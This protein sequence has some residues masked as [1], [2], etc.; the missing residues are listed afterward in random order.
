MKNAEHLLKNLQRIR[1]SESERAKMRSVIDAQIRSNPLPT[2]NPLPFFHF[3]F[4]FQR[5]LIAMSFVALFFVSSGSAF[6][7]EQSLP[8]DVLYGLKR[9]VNEEVRGWFADSPEDRALWQ[10]S[11]AERRLSEIESLSEQNKLSD[12]V[13]MEL[14]AEVDAY[15]QSALQEDS[16]TA[17][18]R[19]AVSRSSTSSLD[20]VSLMVVSSEGGE[21]EEGEALK[22][23]PI[24][25]TEEDINQLAEQIKA[26][27]KNI[28]E[29]RSKDEQRSFIR[30][31]GRLLM[32]EKMVFESKQALKEGDI[33]IARELFLSAE[34]SFSLA[35][36]PIREVVEEEPIVDDVPTED[37]S[38]EE[39][40]G[41]GVISPIETEEVSGEPVR[42]DLP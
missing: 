32:A 13:Q 29:Q 40:E 2:G 22:S 9:G 6:F 41:E 11:L 36:P 33:D 18:D 26:E 4:F 39:A 25:V 17:T 42:E 35:I 21:E 19:E 3:E 15:T 12:E 23:A 38:E 34:V 16:E 37:I 24:P 31:K 5:H 14:S 20:E 7:A 30:A 8:G 27:Q 10:L 1:L 28:Q